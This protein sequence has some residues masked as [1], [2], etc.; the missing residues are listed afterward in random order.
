MTQD[1]DCDG[2]PRFRHVEIEI[3]SHC[4]CACWGCDRFID[5][6]ADAPMT[7][8]QIRHFMDESIAI[9]WEWKRIHILGGE[10]TLHKNL[11]EV[12]ELLLEYRRLFPRCLLRVISNGL[13]KLTEV[14]QF[15]QDNGVDI[16]V[17][18][19]R[20]GVMP[21]WF[22]NAR[23]APID[24]YPDLLAFPPCGIFGVEGCGLGL[25]R[26]GYFLCGAGA[27]VARVAG[28]DIGV[29][30]LSDVTFSIMQKQAESLCK[31][32]GHWSDEEHSPCKIKTHGTQSSEFWKNTLRDWKQ[33]EM[34]VYGGEVEE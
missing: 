25:T 7:V 11:H 16:S 17:E 29:Q 19:K 14:Q 20:R 27:S 1:E 32:C 5:T 33:P 18:G 2:I 31:I 12:I 26:Y 22:T 6:C 30:K 23:L 8:S 21:T 34:T 4:D 10:P 24:L 13:G 3:C 28:L 15:L 9:N